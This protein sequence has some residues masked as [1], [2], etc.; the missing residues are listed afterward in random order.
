MSNEI[1]DFGEFMEVMLAS[2]PD[3]VVNEG[4]NGELIIETGLVCLADDTIVS[5]SSMGE[6]DV[7]DELLKIKLA[8][9]AEWHISLDEMEE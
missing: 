1:N 5:L 6:E 3:A 8:E 7:D 9:E 4:D 2:F